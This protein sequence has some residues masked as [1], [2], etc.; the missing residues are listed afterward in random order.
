MKELSKISVLQQFSPVFFTRGPPLGPYRLLRK[1]KGDITAE[2]ALQEWVDE[3]EVATTA[4][5]MDTPTDVMKEEM[6]CTSCYLQGNAT[7]MYPLQSFGVR[8]RAEL[9]PKYIAQGAWTRCLKRQEKYGSPVT[10]S[11]GTRRGS[12]SAAVVKGECC[13]IC[14]E[15]FLHVPVLPSEHV[16]S[17]C[18]KPYPAVRWSKVHIKNHCRK[19]GTC[20]VCD[21]CTTQGFSPR[22]PFGYKCVTCMQKLGHLKFDSKVLDNAKNQKGSVLRCNECNAK[23]KCS[24]CQNMFAPAQWS[25]NFVKNAEDQGSRLICRSCRAQGCTADDPTI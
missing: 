12:N 4:G 17:A 5:S 9:Y 13:R 6:L 25:A 3:D 8:W 11:L 7:Y 15:R 14:V 20:L 18:E 24:T 2:E 16:C 10:T 22:D 1:L 21:N 23:L 19:R